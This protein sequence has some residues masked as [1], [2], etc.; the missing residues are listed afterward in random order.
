MNVKSYSFKLTEMLFCLKQ[1]FI[2]SE[3]RLNNIPIFWT[4]PPRSFQNV[5]VFMFV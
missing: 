2:L 5:K 4:R 3:Q 1:N